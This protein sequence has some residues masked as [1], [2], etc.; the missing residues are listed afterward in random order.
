LYFVTFK[1]FYFL[2]GKNYL[3]SELTAWKKSPVLG[4]CFST[5]K[6]TRLQASY[7]QIT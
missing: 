4:K 1:Q 6:R 3:E 2:K 5:E 7:I